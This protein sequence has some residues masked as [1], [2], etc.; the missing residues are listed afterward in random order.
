MSPKELLGTIGTG[1]LEPFLFA[2]QPHQALQATQSTDCSCGNHHLLST[3]F[4]DALTEG[5]NAAPAC[6]LTDASSYIMYRV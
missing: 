5:W 4:L 3:S 6:Q 2:N 1:V